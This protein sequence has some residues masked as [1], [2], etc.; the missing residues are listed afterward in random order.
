M[1]FSQSDRKG[2]HSGDVSLFY[3]TQ[4]DA[5]INY[6]FFCDT[7]YKVSK[8]SRFFS[9]VS[10]CDR[11]EWII[12]P[13]NGQPPLICMGMDHRDLSHGFFVSLSVV[14]LLLYPIFSVSA[15]P[16]RSGTEAIFYKVF[17]RDICLGKYR[18]ASA[19]A[20]S[21]DITAYEWVCRMRYLRELFIARWDSISRYGSDHLISL[22]CGVSD[23][24][25][26]RRYTDTY[27][28]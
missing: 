10:D 23:R 17:T 8:G 27:D 18:N 6:T 21:T 1:A 20:R 28:P 14:S 26:W 25:S 9:Y 13:W 5:D 15:D 24:C 22:S 12:S 11:S 3:R 4:S 7:K 16:C 19:S 2:S